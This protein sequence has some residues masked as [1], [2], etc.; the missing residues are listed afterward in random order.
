[1]I[2]PENQLNKEISLVYVIRSNYTLP[3]KQIHTDTKL[4]KNLMEFSGKLGAA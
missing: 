1:M 3:A 4:T 2:S